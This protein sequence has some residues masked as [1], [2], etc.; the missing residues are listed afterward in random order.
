[1][2]LNNLH[3][4][5]IRKTSD[6]TYYIK[7]KVSV[8]FYDENDKRFLLEKEYPI[9]LSMKKD[10]RFYGNKYRIR[11]S[12]DKLCNKISNDFK[13]KKRFIKFDFKKH[14]ILMNNNPINFLLISDI[15]FIDFCSKD[16]PNKVAGKGRSFLRTKKIKELLNS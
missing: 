12:L 6:F 11:K 2:K 15:N 13:I 3:N 7:Y 1:M 14:Y 16:K 5:N 9:G 10:F 4:F 8:Y